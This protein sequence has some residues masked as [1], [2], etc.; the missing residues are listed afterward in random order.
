MGR[1]VDAS[2]LVGSQEIA[3]RLGLRRYQHV[4][5]YREHDPTFPEPVARIGTGR[6]TLIWY[7]P[8][9]EAWAKRAGRLEGQ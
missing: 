6:G 4:H 8:D 9:I 2:L 1:S 5:W 7:W 3:E